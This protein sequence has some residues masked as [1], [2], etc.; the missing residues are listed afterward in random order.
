MTKTLAFALTVLC[1]VSTVTASGQIGQRFPDF[2]FK[3]LQGR[4]VALAQF[5]GKVVLLN[6]WMTTCPPCR[7]EMPALQKLQQKYAAHGLAVVGISADGDAGI[8]SSFARKLG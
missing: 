8:A 2:T 6:L 7:K 1:A 5:R 4:D 3:N